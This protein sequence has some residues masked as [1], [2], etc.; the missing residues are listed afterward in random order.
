MRGAALGVLCVVTCGPLLLACPPAPPDLGFTPSTES[1]HELLAAQ[2]EPHATAA[3]PDQ[4]NPNGNPTSRAYIISPS[5]IYESTSTAAGFPTTPQ[6]SFGLLSTGVS[7]RGCP[8]K[9]ISAGDV[10]VLVSPPGSFNTGVPGFNGQVMYAEVLMFSSGTAFAN[11]S[12]DQ[13]LLIRSG[14]DGSFT[15]S[16]VQCVTITKPESTAQVDKGRWRCRSQGG[17]PRFGWPGKTPDAAPSWAFPAAGRAP[18]RSTPRRGSSQ[19]APRTP[20]RSPPPS[21]RRFWGPRPSPST[22]EAAHHRPMPTPS[23]S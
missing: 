5:G 2:P 15:G 9:I 20:V 22:W 12:P 18:C 13:V 16:N 4:P 11:D 7:G 19:A 21:G 23:S 10:D 6:F 1:A 14:D 8:E 17:R 3:L